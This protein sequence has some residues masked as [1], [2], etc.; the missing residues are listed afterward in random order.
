MVKTAKETPTILATR[1]AD[2]ERHAVYQQAGCTVL[3]VP[4]KSG[5]V[6]LKELMKELDG[7][8]LTV[9]FWKGRNAELGGAWRVGLFRKIGHYIAPKLFG[10]GKRKPAEG[11]DF[12]SPD[13]AVF[14]R[15]RDNTSGEDFLV[16]SEVRQDV[17]RAH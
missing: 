12:I 6:D 17:Y 5:C 11:R 7:T 9:F 15:Q 10:A 3:A 4:E 14:E 13:A 8:V 2:K 1:N 16:E